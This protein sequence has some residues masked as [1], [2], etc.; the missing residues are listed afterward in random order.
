MPVQR[1]S[2]SIPR[3]S[4]VERF[5]LQSYEYF[6]DRNHVFS[7]ITGVQPA[8]FI[9]RGEGR[10]CCASTTRRKA[11]SGWAAATCANSIRRSCGASS[12]CLAGSVP[13]A[14]EDAAEQVNLLDFINSLPDGFEH[15]IRELGSG[16]S[17]GQKDESGTSPA[18]HSSGQRLVGF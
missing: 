1:S 9:V 6:L 17:T 7:G 2:A 14:V 15:S 8:R 13:K 12:A 4:S 16:L 10:C 5:S 11:P 3:R 18:G